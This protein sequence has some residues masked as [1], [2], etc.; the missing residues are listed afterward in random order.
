[1]ALKIVGIK[2]SEPT[3]N[4]RLPQ[5]EK[6]IFAARKFMKAVSLLLP[7]LIEKLLDGGSIDGLVGRRG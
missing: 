1:M 5:R 4:Q 3:P 2:I 7:Q 6:T